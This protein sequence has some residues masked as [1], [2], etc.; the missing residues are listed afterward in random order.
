MLPMYMGAGIV[1]PDFRTSDAFD[2][3]ASRRVSAMTR[4]LILAATSYIIAMMVVCFPKGFLPAV[5]AVPKRVYAHLFLLL[6]A[7]VGEAC[8]LVSADLGTDRLARHPASPNIH[9]T[10]HPSPL[11]RSLNWTVWGFALWTLSMFA[12]E[13]LVL[14]GMG[15]AVWCRGKIPPSP[16]PMATCRFFYVCLL[17]LHLTR[18]VDGPMHGVCMPPRGALVIL[19]LNCVPEL[20][21]FR[22]PF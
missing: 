13:M 4:R 21:P 10:H 8:F 2:S 17:H 16:P 12:G 15:H 3:P 14:S 18:V 7:P 11:H 9:H 20:G 5:F 1:A 6:S 19:G 22:W